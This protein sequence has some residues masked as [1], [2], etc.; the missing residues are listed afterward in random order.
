MI[1]KKI[2]RVFANI[3]SS[4]AL[5]ACSL[6]IRHISRKNLYLFAEKL[7]TVGYWLLARHRRVAF[8]GLSHAFGK[9][10]SPA[11]IKKIARDCFIY[12]AKSSSE[13]AF[14]IGR[15]GFIRSSSTIEGQEHLDQ[16]LA[17]GKG[18]I[19][20]SGHF[21]NFVLMLAKLSID[22][23]KTSVIMR[24]L[25]NRQIEGLF[26]TDRAKLDI[27]TISSIPRTA[28][29]ANTIKALRENRLLLIPLDQN[30]G[31][32]GVYVDFFGRKAATA[33]G[34]VVLAQRTGAAILPCFIIRQKDDTHRIVFEPALDLLKGKD[35]AETIVNNIQRITKI[36]ESYIRRYP[37]EWSWIHRRW[38]SRPKEN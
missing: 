18:V 38:K 28:C 11:E 20:V 25:K 9:T 24:P 3:L 37:Q 4:I 15:P 5:I 19:L 16:A 6:I 17:K 12:M 31:T 21:G 22:G 26:E 14:V 32:S 36:I 7:G 2:K 27:N 34:P 1:L 30:F 29:V 33:T 8:E 23:Y 35:E 13:L 10:K